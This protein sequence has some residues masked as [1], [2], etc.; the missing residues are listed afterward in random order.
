VPIV[1]GCLLYVGW[2][3]P[4]VLVVGLVFATL[5][6]GS[7][8]MMAGRAQVRI[9]E[10][11]TRQDSLVGHFRTLVHGFR[12][13]RQHRP[14]RLGF[15]DQR[16]APQAEAVRVSATRGFSMYAVVLSWGQLAYFGFLGIVTFG[17]PHLVD[18]GRGTTAAIVVVLLFLMGPLDWLISWL[19]MLGAAQ[20]SLKRIDDMLP[21][22]DGDAKEEHAEP[23][24]SM[25]LTDSIRLGGLTYAY[26][27]GQ[28]AGEDA[29][30]LGP[31]DLTIRAGEVVVLAGGNGSGKTTLLKLLT[32]LYE[33]DEGTIE[34][35]GRP[36]K[37]ADREAYRQLFSVVFNDGHL[38]G[39]LVGIE[40]DGLDAKA[41]DGL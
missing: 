5:A 39:D 17:L 35:D 23:I 20:A 40:A 24:E 15:L 19:P 22:L 32:G 18:Q 36:V 37:A 4:V 41:A 2:L 28:G 14:R 31:I 13:L 8:L 9:Q 1:V 6:I 33:A 27:H 25:T 34:L 30:Q 10:A 29:F 3:S 21:L 26:G 7:Y 12:E 38:F 16:L 11:R